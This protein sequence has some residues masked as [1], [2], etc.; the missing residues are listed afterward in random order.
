V[1]F[2]HRHVRAAAREAPRGVESAGAAPDYHDIVHRAGSFAVH[3]AS[4]ND[5]TEGE[6]R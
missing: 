4:V 5:E 1:L 2:E 3:S 6:R